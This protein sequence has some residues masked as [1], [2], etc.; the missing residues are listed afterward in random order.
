MEISYPNLP[1][2]NTIFCDDIRYEIGNKRSLI[3]I[4]STHM[5]LNEIPCTINKLCASVYFREEPD[6]PHATDIRVLH[7]SIMDGRDIKDAR[8]DSFD[9]EVLIERR[10]MEVPISAIK[11]KGE[12]FSFRFCVLDFT[13]TNLII[14]KPCRIKVRAY[15]EDLEIRLGSLII[16]ERENSN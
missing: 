12:F 16:D 6:S 1:S 5:F 11:D 14:T 15:Q 4:Y 10:F 3:G 7:D 9:N 13:M 2:G 8:D